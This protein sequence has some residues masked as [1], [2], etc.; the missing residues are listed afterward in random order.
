MRLPDLIWPTPRLIMAVGAALPLAVVLVITNPDWWLGAAVYLV[1]VGAAA[2]ADHLLTAQPRQVTVS[3]GR[4]DHLYMADQGALDLRVE[5]GQRGRGLLVEVVVDTS[6]LLADIDGSTLRLDGGGSGGISLPLAPQRRGIAQIRR[7]WLRWRGPM[8]L[9]WRTRREDTGLTVQVLPNLPAV[10]RAAI[11]LASRAATFGDKPE[12]SPG[13]GVEFD[14]LRE[15]LPGMDLRAVDWKHSARHRKLVA[16]EFKS[17]RNHNII[18]AFDTGQLMREPIDG[19][20]KLDHAINAGLILAY[21]ALSEGD[22]VGVYG[23][24]ERPGVYFR[25]VAGKPKFSS[26]L[27]QINRL[28][29]STEETNFTLGLGSLLHSLKR[30]S[31]IILMTDVLDS[32]AA[33]LMVRNVGRMARQHTVVFAALREPWTDAAKHRQP[34]SVTDLVEMVVTMELDAERAAVLERLRR[35]GITLIDVTPA[36]LN[37]ALLNQYLAVKRQSAVQLA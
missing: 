34:A 26:L 36:R 10:K 8:G 35:M 5:A 30:P 31:I 22:L 24:G 7:I 16:K 1:A 11:Q 23:F 12:L 14:A 21:Q 20:P 4:V 9:V 15:H 2:V 13:E 19:T 33:E 3:A 18:L 28:E 6:D 32:V 17:E 27:S 37:T 29:Y 25:P